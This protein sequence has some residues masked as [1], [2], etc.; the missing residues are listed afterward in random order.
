MEL[1]VH[2]PL[3]RFGEQQLSRQRLEAI[4][5]AA[6]DLVGSR[7]MSANDHLVFQAPWLDGL[8][9]LASMISTLLG[10]MALATTVSL[11]VPRGPVPLA[12]A[13]AAIDLLSQGRLVA[14]LGPGSSERFVVA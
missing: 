11:P 8:A 6:S 14:A 3:M 10:Q 12:K 13:L 1:D 4:V 9:A 2:L 7:A 5:D